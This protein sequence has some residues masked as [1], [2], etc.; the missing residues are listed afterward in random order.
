MSPI[1]RISILVAPI[2]PIFVFLC[3]LFIR[4]GCV[5]GPESVIV[6]A[7]PSNGRRQDSLMADTV[8]YIQGRF[9]P[10]FHPAFKEVPTVWASRSGMYLRAETLAAFSKLAEAAKQQG[11]KLQIISATRNFEAQKKIWEN[12]WTGKTLIEDG[13]NLAASQLSPE[14]KA[15]KIL[16]YSSMP[17]TSRHHWGTDIDLNNL[18]NEYF[19]SGAGKKLYDWLQLHAG[20]FGFC[21]PY[22]AGRLA[23]YKEEKWHWTYLP[24]SRPLTSF[25]KKNFQNHLIQGFLGAETAGRLQILENYMLGINEE[26]K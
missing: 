15:A 10:A 9:D 17:S 4:I 22:T 16:E 8:R 25:C 18:T 1:N 2:L 26:C 21:Q 5:S 11:L 20:S 6:P 14:Q 12:K 3:Q 13:Q 19:E 7:D 23:G 24:I